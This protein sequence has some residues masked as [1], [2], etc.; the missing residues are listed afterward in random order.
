MVG[1]DEADLLDGHFHIL[2]VYFNHQLVIRILY[3]G[4]DIGRDIGPA[5]IAPAFKHHGEVAELIIVLNH[6]GIESGDKQN[7]VDQL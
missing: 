7:I 5:H 6:L 1:S 3:N 4:L 2:L